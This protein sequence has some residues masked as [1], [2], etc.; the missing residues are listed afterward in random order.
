ML[1]EFHVYSKVNQLYIYIYIHSF[2]FFS[3]IGHYRVFFKIFY[4]ILFIYFPYY[5]YFFWLRRV[6]VAAH[7][8]FVEACGIFSLRRA[9]CSGFSLVAALRLLSSCG[10]RVFSL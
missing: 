10:V 9:V 5:Y 1:C 4:F 7:G 2:R 6:L 8:I 3:H